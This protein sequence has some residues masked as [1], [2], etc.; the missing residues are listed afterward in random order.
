MPVAR[1]TAGPAS[2]PASRRAEGAR[3]AN[4]RLIFETIFHRGPISRVEI[5]G[6]IGLNA[7]TIS[8]ITRDLIDEGLITE[9]GRST[10]LRGQPQIYLE[11]NAR[12]GYSVGVHLDR[13]FCLL[14]LSDLKRHELVRRHVR[15][16]TRQPRQTLERV[17]GELASALAEAGAPRERVWGI[18]LVL[19]TF[20]SAVYDFDFSMPHWEAWRDVGFADELRELT[21]L[22][23]LVENDATAAAIGERFH[24]GDATSSTFVYFYVGRG[25]GAGLIIDGAPFKGAFGNAGEMGLL[26]IFGLDGSP[27]W[28]EQKTLDV[29]SQGGMARACDMAED[30]VD[31]DEV[32]R[33][34]QLR[35]HRLMEWLKSASDTLRDLTAVFEVLFDPEFIAVGGGL[36]RQIIQTLVDMAYPLRP[37]PAA[38]RDRTEARLV[39]AELIEDAAVWG[40]ALLPIFINTSPSF[41]TL[42]ARQITQVQ[43]A[44]ER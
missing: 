34:H 41:R 16:D 40:A 29:L 11:P 13:D 1:K 36:P 23:V 35:D 32:I 18:G 24:R 31:A 22:P 30:A 43:R 6:I 12:A 4:R 38:R 21:G 2:A 42:Y 15:C 27:V 28:P 5:G 8:S 19:P 10:G 39:A 7:Q 20:G 44:F 9:A 37:T 25:T 26:P 17:A 33:L 14:V 3:L